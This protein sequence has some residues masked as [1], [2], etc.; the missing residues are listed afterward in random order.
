MAGEAVNGTRYDLALLVVWI[1]VAT[2]L[3]GFVSYAL[4]SIG[5]D[6]VGVVRRVVAAHRRP[7]FPDRGDR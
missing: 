2:P 7:L 1:L 6:L 3:I 4:T 5:R